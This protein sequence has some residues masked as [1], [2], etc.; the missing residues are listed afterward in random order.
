MISVFRLEFKGSSSLSAFS[1]AYIATV[2]AEGGGLWSTYFFLNI[3]KSIS[4]TCELG[5]FLLFSSTAFW[6]FCSNFNSIVSGSTTLEVVQSHEFMIQLR[7]TAPF[8]H[9]FKILQ[10]NPFW[11]TRAE[12]WAQF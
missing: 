11:L 9:S 4:F 6:L 7:R 5:G 8:L 10:H 1:R 3:Q 2:Y 12:L